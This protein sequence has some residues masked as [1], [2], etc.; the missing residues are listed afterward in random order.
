[1]KTKRKSRIVYLV[2]PSEEIERI[3]KENLGSITIKTIVTH[4]N[5][6]FI[7]TTGE[8]RKVKTNLG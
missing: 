4:S 8:N 1:M 2:I 5:V 7:T 3:N 6:K